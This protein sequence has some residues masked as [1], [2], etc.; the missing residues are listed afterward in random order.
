M[1][2]WAT[3]ILCVQCC[4]NNISI[5]SVSLASHFTHHP[6]A[7]STL[8]LLLASGPLNKCRPCPNHWNHLLVGNHC[9]DLMHCRT[10]WNIVW[11]C[12][13]TIF[14]CTWVA[15]HPNVPCLKK[16]EANGWIESCIWNPLLS[17]V[18][19]RLPL[20]ICALLVPKYVLAWAIKQFL[21]AQDIAKQN[22]GEFNT[23]S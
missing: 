20:F 18:E 10:I 17:F 15:V 19:H 2:M 3:C 9:N 4:S 6:Y 13:V 8:S 21:V 5:K 11:S 12:L 14:S 23:L 22:K 16:W 1:S 7:L